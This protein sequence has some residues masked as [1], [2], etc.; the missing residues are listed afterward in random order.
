MKG[1]WISVPAQD[2]QAFRAYRSAPKGSGPGLLVCHDASGVSA[3]VLAFADLMAEEGYTVLMPDLSDPLEAR[4]AA[5]GRAIRESPSFK[6]RVGI[7]GFGM[8][9]RLAV[10]GAAACGAEC[11]VSYHGEGLDSEIETLGR[12]GVATVLHFAEN[13]SLVSAEALQRIARAISERKDAELYVYRDAERGVAANMAY[14]R[15]LA[16]LRKVLGPR[17]DLSALWERHRACEFDIRDADATLRTMVEEPYVNHIPTMTGGFGQAD[18]HRFYKN[19]FIP[20]SP[21][22]MKNIPVSRTV[23][24]DRVVNEGVLCFTHDVEIDWMLPGI[25]PTGRYVEV[26]IVGIITFRGDKL[27]HEHIYWDQASVLVQ[28]GLLDPAGLPVA[29]I[30]TAKKV[31]DPSRPSNT[32]LS[33]RNALRHR[34]RRKA[35][36]SR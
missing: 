2:G 5:A 33:R 13:D 30:E 20:K 6:G 21:K 24:A 7:L 35:R 8:G 32:L 9:G 17:F 3:D 34:A 23:G 31:L 18:L 4:I 22:D 36:S 29:G 14:T 25:P 15:T 10:A 28:I 11:A 12:E 1:E 27:V 16:L 26:P 19:H